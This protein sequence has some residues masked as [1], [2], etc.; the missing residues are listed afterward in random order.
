ME[1]L[2]NKV[3]LVAGGS[4]GIGLAIGRALGEAGC[5]VVLSARSVDKLEAEA[6]AMTDRGVGAVAHPADLTEEKAVDT[7]FEA[8]TQRFGRLD[9]LVNATGAFDGGPIDR[10]SLEAWNR[11]I[12]TNL[13]APFLCTRAA[14]RIMKKQRSGRILNIGSTSAKRVRPDTAPYC[15]SKFALAGLSES[16]ALEGREFGITCCCL[17]PGNVRV[18]RRRHT[19]LPE[20]DE[21]MIDT[22]QIAALA[23]TMAAMPGHA[24]VLEATVLPRD[25][26]YVGRG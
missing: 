2:K 17:H 14:M 24:T 11:V 4:S 20:D 22:E 1:T 23:L 16:T 9:F 26:L 5:S 13:T 21:P 10:L 8:V 7:L 25:Q 3:A 15:A 19:G 12:S 6:A 18:E